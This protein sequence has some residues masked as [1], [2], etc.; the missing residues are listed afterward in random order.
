MPDV[1]AGIR[2]ERNDGANEKIVAA[3]R[4]ARLAVPGGSVADTHVEEI[5]IGVIDDGVPDGATSAALRPLTLPSSCCFFENGSF[6]KLRKVARHRVKAPS[7]FS[8]S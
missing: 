5:K 2:L 6:K 1:F 8:S 4:A 7:K 3:V